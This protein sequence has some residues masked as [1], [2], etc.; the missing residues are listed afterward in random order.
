MIACY[1]LFK[2]TCKANVAASVNPFILP[3][4]F[5]LISRLLSME[6]GSI[7]STIE[8]KLKD[9]FEPVYLEVVNES[10]KHSVPKGSESHFKVN[11]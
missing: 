10:Y 6:N 9:K 7:Q 2:L 4:K 11:C 3:P 5:L 8:K 1:K